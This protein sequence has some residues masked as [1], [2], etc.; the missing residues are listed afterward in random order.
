[1]EVKFYLRGMLNRERR[2]L[3]R[4]EKERILTLYIKQ[5]VVL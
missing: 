3:N 5:S 2:K 4:R 1:M